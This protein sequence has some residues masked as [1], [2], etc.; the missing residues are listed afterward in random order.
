DSL[1]ARGHRVIG[2]DN[3]VLGRR[4]NL[5]GALKNPHFIFRELDVNDLDATVAF[6]REQGTID[7]VWHMAANSDIPAG[8]N[9][10]DVDL[11]LT[12]LTTFNTLKAMHTLGIPR[13]AFA[14]SS[15]IYGAHDGD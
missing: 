6:L 13:L 8:V 10:P 2:A 4:E 15:A 7:E 5:A 12:F 9:N 14:S 3:L 11:S 1:L